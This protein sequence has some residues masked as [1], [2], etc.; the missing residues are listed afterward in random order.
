MPKAQRIEQAGPRQA[1]V[2]AG[3][4]VCI[5]CPCKASCSCWCGFSELTGYMI[6]AAGFKDVRLGLIHRAKLALRV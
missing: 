2:M 3:V 1:A 6:Y 5:G 4:V